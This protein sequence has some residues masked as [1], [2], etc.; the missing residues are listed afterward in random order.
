M[1]YKTQADHRSSMMISLQC[2]GCLRPRLVLEMK[3]IEVY[4]Y[5]GR[6]SMMGLNC[7]NASTNSADVKSSTNSIINRNIVA[8]LSNNPLTPPHN[9]FVFSLHTT[10]ATR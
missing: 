4:S 1:P 9:A 7:V 3:K 5:I 10:T 2:F 6:R 8:M